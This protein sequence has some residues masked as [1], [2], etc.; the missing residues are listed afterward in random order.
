MNIFAAKTARIFHDI[1][2]RAKKN[3]IPPY[4]NLVN[5]KSNTMKNTLQCV[6]NHKHIAN[7]AKKKV[8]GFSFFY[9][10]C[11]T[12]RLCFNRNM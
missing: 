12:K 1:G 10:S 5:L 3:G 11:A 6:Q 4:P 7:T 8:I 2:V 9:D